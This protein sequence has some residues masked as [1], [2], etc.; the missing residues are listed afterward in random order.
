MFRKDFELNGVAGWS[1]RLM[2]KR[3]TLFQLAEMAVRVNLF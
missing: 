2:E 3:P 1:F